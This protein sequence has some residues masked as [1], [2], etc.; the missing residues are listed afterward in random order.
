[1][2]K[3]NISNWFPRKRMRSTFQRGGRGIL[4]QA[5]NDLVR[6]HGEIYI[7][8]YINK[9]IVRR[10]SNARRVVRREPKVLKIFFTIILSYFHVLLIVNAWLFF[11]SASANIRRLFPCHMFCPFVYETT[12]GTARTD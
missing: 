11:D 9:G 5:S 2:I 6:G 4:L 12:L 3:V 10:I 7:F 1:M 8:V